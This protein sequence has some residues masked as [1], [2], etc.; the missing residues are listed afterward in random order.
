MKIIHNFK[1]I[2]KTKV[3]N[4]LYISKLIISKIHNE[5]SMDL[6]IIHNFK[7]NNITRNKTKATYNDK[8]HHEISMDPANYSQFQND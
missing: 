4:H 6:E 8:K 1:M 2:S 7:M 5:I 3:F